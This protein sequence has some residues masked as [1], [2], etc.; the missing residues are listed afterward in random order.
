MHT[1]SRRDEWLGAIA[2]IVLLIG[3]AIGNANAMLGMSVVALFLMAI[4]CRKQLGRGAALVALVAA[5]AAF[6][7]AIV[8]AIR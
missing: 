4:F 5:V 7:I 1:D 2:V 6:L 8:M 3:T